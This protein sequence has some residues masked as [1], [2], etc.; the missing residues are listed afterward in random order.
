MAVLLASGDD[1]VLSHGSAAALWG[2]GPEWRPI[3]VTVRHRVWS[4]LSDVK[5]R[6]RPLLPDQDVTFHRRIPVTTV[7][8][9]I[10]DQAS[11]PISDASLERR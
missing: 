5:G 3:E 4:R 6:A 8:R 7:A 1:A 9:T 11:T 2:I 10:L